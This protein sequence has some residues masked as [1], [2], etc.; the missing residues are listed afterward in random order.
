MVNKWIINRQNN[1]DCKYRLFCLP[2]AGSGAS[3][4][5]QWY[6][7]VDKEIEVC[8]IQLPGRENRRN[9]T[10][11]KDMQ[12]IITEITDAIVD[13]LD[14][15]FAI[16]G[17]SM[18][19]ILAYE[20]T[21]KLYER[22]HVKPKKLFM[23][24]ASLFR[25]KKTLEVS[26]MNERQLTEYL[27]AT[28]GVPAE[29]LSNKY[30]RQEYF[31]IIQNDYSLVEEY[32][33][34]YRKVPCDIVAFASKEDQEVFYKNI[35]L[36]RFFTNNFEVYHMKGNHFFIRYEYKKIGEMISDI[37]LTESS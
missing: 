16:F 33:F 31:P 25:D 6:Q 23:S 30:F 1:K 19:G 29:I 14:K 9:E 27:K 24:A 3:L 28:G 37:M 34:G 21:V 15:P 36:L 5:A 13:L 18:G 7:Y 11:C 20:L 8:P 32:K 17:Y 12:Q 4:Y 2:Y 10:L 35:K 22:F 26:C